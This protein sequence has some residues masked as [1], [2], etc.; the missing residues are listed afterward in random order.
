MNKS[1]NHLGRHID[2]QIAQLHDPTKCTPDASH[3][4]PQRCALPK[5][6]S[7]SYLF[8]VN[9]NSRPTAASQITV[10]LATTRHR[11]HQS[12]DD[13][14]R[15]RLLYAQ[16]HI[17]FRSRNCDQFTTGLKPVSS[18]LWKCLLLHTVD[19][20]QYKFKSVCCRIELPSCP[21]V[22]QLILMSKHLLI[23]LRP[24]TRWS[25]WKGRRRERGCSRCQRVLQLNGH[26][27]VEK[28]SHVHLLLD[29]CKATQTLFVR[30]DR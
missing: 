21:V 27:R 24:H 1:S 30:I 19:C 28:F 23:S 22:G 8:C 29:S 4:N 26:Q 7:T 9:V 20:T 12:H 25:S 17:V 13:V 10:L 18:A 5:P 14:C 2:T 11:S 16:Q 6:G 15:R 3:L